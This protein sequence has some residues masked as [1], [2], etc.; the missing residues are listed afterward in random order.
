VR[1]LLDPLELEKLAH[2]A[3]DPLRSPLDLMADFA[4]SL[5]VLFFVA[6]LGVVALAFT[7]ADIPGVIP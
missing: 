1:R 6:V 4:R 7:L 2:R 5:A 3:D